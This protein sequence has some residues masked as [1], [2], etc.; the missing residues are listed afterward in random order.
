MNI[1]CEEGL[2]DVHVFGGDICMKRN[3]ENKRRE[4][5]CVVQITPH[6]RHMTKYQPHIARDAG[7]AKV[8]T[9]TDNTASSN[10]SNTME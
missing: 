9:V 7:T 6:I 2:D 1:P 3:I 4:S 8:L 10:Q 5:K